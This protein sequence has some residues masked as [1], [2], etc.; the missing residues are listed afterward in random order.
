MKLMEKLIE[1]LSEIRNDVDFENC[2]E[3]VDDDIL[4]SL[5]ILQIIAMISSEY[6]IEVPQKEIVPENFNSAKL[7][8]E[9]IQRLED[10]I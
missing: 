8:Y 4:E 3:L 9:M 2:E 5:D 1:L 6:D 7:I 10:E